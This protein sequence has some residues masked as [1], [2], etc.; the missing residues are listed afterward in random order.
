MSG[1]KTESESLIDKAV[2][3]MPPAQRAQ[4]SALC[5]R[6]EQRDSEP[7][8]LVHK[9]SVDTPRGENRRGPPHTEHHF[10]QEG[11]DRKVR[12]LDAIRTVLGP[13]AAKLPL[14]H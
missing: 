9:S 12:R 13:D 5:P 2:K 6:V 14:P 10:D 7:V 8:T 11:H 1:R 4:L 3:R